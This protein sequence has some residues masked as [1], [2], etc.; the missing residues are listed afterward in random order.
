VLESEDPPRGAW[1]N[2]ERRKRIALSRALWPVG[3]F[4]AVVMPLSTEHDYNILPRAQLRM[5]GKG[6]ED[7]ARRARGTTGDMG[8]WW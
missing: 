6:S 4:R 5:F 1:L 8:T 3:V 2:L 7:P